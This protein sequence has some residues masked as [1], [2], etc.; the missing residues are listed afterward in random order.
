LAGILA[1]RREGGMSDRYAPGDTCPDCRN[2]ILIFEYGSSG[3]R[4]DP[5]ESDELYCES[6]GVDFDIDPRRFA[7][8][9]VSCQIAEDLFTCHA[10]LADT[11]KFFKSNRDLGGWSQKA[12]VDLIA[13]NLEQYRFRN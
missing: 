3:T 11:L 4:D 10:G 2:G 12:V 9:E 1:N 5:P 13:K 6:C 8:R 7:I